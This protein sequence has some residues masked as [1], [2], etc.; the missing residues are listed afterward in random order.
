[1]HRP[2]VEGD[3][4]GLVV[5]PGEGVLHPVLVV[6][7]GEVLAR[8]GPAALLP[9]QGAGDRHRRLAEVH[10]GKADLKVSDRGLIWNT[11]LVET[12]ELDNLIGNALVT[13]AGALNRQESRGAHAREDFPERDDKTW[14]KH[15]LAWL[16]EAGKVR[17]DDRPVHAFTLTNDVAYIP[18]KA[19]V[20]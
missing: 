14:M 5:E 18:P 11:D 19:R 9:V 7:L 10:A 2:V 1:M 20:Y 4:A 13:V 3:L 12:L 8:V 16:D 15:T 17:L 6:A